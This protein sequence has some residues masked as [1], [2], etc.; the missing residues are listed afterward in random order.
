[1][2]REIHPSG[3]FLVPGVGAQGASPDQGLASANEDGFGALVVASRS[4]LFP[5]EP[6]RHEN[7]DLTSNGVSASVLQA[8]LELKEQ[9]IVSLQ[10]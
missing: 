2:Y 3:W 9:L 7:Y 1:M 10:R 6:H 5:K 8:T 4:L